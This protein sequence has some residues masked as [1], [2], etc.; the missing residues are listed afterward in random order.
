MT[1]PMWRILQA[2]WRDRSGATAIEYA[3]VALFVSILI[4]AGATAVGT[5]LSNIFVQVANGF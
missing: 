5:S 4:V 1:N 2:L 3:L